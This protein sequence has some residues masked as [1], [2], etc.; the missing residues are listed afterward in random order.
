MTSPAAPSTCHDALDPAAVVP[1]LVLDT[2]VVLDWLVFRHPSCARLADHVG[3]GRIRWIASRAMRD[4]LAHV[5]QRG[6]VD[7]WAPDLATLWA[8][9]EQHARPA[10]SIALA[11]DA[12]RLRCTDSDDQ[13]FIDLALAHRARWLLSR[14]RAVLKVARRARLLG[15]EVLTPDAWDSHLTAD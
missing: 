5:L 7:A 12:T 15:L 8:T 4:E 14:D 10:E 1:A 6:V 11:G 13:K 9:W 2:N 3:A